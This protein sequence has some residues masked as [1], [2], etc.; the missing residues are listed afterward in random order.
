[1]SRNAT[2][3]YTLVAGNPVVTGTVIESTWA[4]NTLADMTAAMTDSLSRSG[5][6]GMLVPMKVADGSAA[7]PS[8][9]FTNFPTSGMYMAGAGD[10]RLS[11]TGIDRLRLLAST[12][13]AE[14]RNTTNTAWVDILDEEGGQSVNG[15]T[16]TG[17]VD[18]TSTGYL[19]VSQGT[20]AQR[21]VVS[22]VGQLRFNSTSGQYEGN[23]T[24]GWSEIGNSGD[25]DGGFAATVYSPADTIIDSGGA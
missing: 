21:P 9:S 20:T 14:V 24:G 10:V 13:R 7:N 18:N 3:T 25:Y 11:V 16:F 8:Y 2:G 15:M 23:Y 17:D 12:N 1:M 6:G 4:N 5:L 22:A 19:Q